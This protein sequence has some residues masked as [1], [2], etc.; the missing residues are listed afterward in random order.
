MVT[1][2]A[3]VFWTIAPFFPAQLLP[4]SLHWKA[5]LYWRVVCLLLSPLII[6]FPSIWSHALSLPQIGNLA[7]K[8]SSAQ[9]LDRLCAS[10]L[11]RQ[12]LICENRASTISS[13][14]TALQMAVV[15]QNAYHELPPSLQEQ[16]PSGLRSQS[17]RVL[18]S[19]P[20]AVQRLA[21][22]SS[23]S[24]NAGTAHA[25]SANAKRHAHKRKKVHYLPQTDSKQR[26]G[27][28]RH[29]SSR[30]GQTHGS[31]YFGIDHKNEKHH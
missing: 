31:Q 26:P 29:V 25:S 18:P 28:A 27:Q 23:S 21:K 17:A 15:V 5:Q 9:V 16:P 7:F 10:H 24:L 2:N 11:Y 12:A 3:C 22:L 19:S 30:L 8:Q 6:S 4:Y 14:E 20:T 1:A 13:P